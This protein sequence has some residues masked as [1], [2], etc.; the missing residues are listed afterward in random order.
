METLSPECDIKDMFLLIDYKFAKWKG[1]IQKNIC[2]LQRDEL[3]TDF[4]DVK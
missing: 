4:N 3:L 2:L 1:E